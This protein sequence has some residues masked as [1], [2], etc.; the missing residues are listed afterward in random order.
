MKNLNYT[1][2]TLHILERLNNSK[3]GNPRYLIE[4]LQDNGNV[5]TLKTPIDSM[6]AYGIG[7]LRGKYIGATWRMLRGHPTLWNTATFQKGA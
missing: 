5:L 4:I 1:K 2:G 6:L 7:N 3:N